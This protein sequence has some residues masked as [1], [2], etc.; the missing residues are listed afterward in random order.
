MFV[1]NNFIYI[2]KY[3]GQTVVTSLSMTTS[4]FGVWSFCEECH[5]DVF[6][7]DPE[8]VTLRCLF[9][10]DQGAIRQTSY[11]IETTSSGTSPVKRANHDRRSR[12]KLPR[13][14]ECSFFDN[15]RRRGAAKNV[16]VRGFNKKVLAQ[17]EAT[18]T[19]PGKPIK[20]RAQKIMQTTTFVSTL[21]R[22]ECPFPLLP[23]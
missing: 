23:D 2:N 9:P 8:V 11:F 7:A 16:N 17:L 19:L 13:L 4:F 22:K 3:I 15:S 1:D 14:K 10:C 6:G 20:K 5:A 21:A 12:G 18:H